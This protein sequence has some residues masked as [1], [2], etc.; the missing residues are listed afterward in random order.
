MALIEQLQKNWILRVYCQRAKAKIYMIF[1]DQLQKHWILRVYC[2]RAK[3][4]ICMIFIDQ[5]QK[6]TG[7]WEFNVKEQRHWSA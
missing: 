2:Q 1:I 7:Y 5:L 6:K 3:A 4:L